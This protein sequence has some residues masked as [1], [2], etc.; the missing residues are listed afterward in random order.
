[1]RRLMF[2]VLA[3]SAGCRFEG[4][5]PTPAGVLPEPAWTG[6]LF[7][8]ATA[9]FGLEQVDPPPPEDDCEVATYMTR[10]GAVGDVNGDGRPD[11]F[12]PHPGGED[13]LFFGGVH[14]FERAPFDG[15]FGAGAILFDAD[16]DADLDLFVTSVGLHP[17]RFYDNDGRGRF[18]LR[19]ANLAF[20]V[21]PNGCHHLFGAS[22]SDFDGDGDLDLFTAAW[23]DAD[24]N[25]VFANDGTGHFT[26]VSALL[27]DPAREAAGLVPF[28]ADLD[29]DGDIDF[30]L[31]SDFHYTRHY[32]GRGDGTFEDLTA[33]STIPRIQDAM[34]VAAGDVDLDGDLDL[35]FSGICHTVGDGCNDAFFWTGNRHFFR[36]G[37][38]YRDATVEAGTQDAGWAWGS[39]LFDADLDGDLDLAVTNGYDFLARFEGDPIDYFDN[40]GTGAFT[41]RAAEVGLD[42]DRQTRSVIPFDADHDGDLDLLVLATDGPPRLYENHAT[43]AALTVTLRA[44]PPNVHGVGA[45]VFAELADG[46]RLRRDV[47]LSSSYLST[48]PADAHF[49]LGDS[50]VSALEVT[51]PDGHVQR[52]TP[53]EG[54]RWITIER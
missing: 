49:G 37:D 6:P 3:V 51:W 28:P 53:A 13:R 15:A 14:G 46:R 24:G 17:P 42:D 47:L 21:D 1:M 16:G 26:D 40:D 20:G 29:D 23:V 30:V 31:A 27:G 32:E 5:A 7:A 22:A 36:E 11:V 48:R 45:R 4:A 2:A 8:D 18:T 52:V 9:A 35:F 10:G 34:S 25:R 33:T 44:P 12:L 50:T 54:A 41:E 43:G 39:A 38:G 19:D